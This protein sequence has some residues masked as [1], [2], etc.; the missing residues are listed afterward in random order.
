MSRPAPRVLT[1]VL[2]VLACW[3]PSAFA[4]TEITSCGQVVTGK[5]FLSAD[6]DCTGYDDEVLVHELFHDDEDA[7]V[8]GAAVIVKR[9]G[10]IELRGHTLTGGQLGIFC[11]KSCTVLGGGVTVT[12]SVVHGI[13]AS[14]NLTIK[15]TTVSNNGEAGLFV[16][17][18]LRATGCTI[19]GNRSGTWISATIKL[20]SSTVTGNA[21]FG[22]GADGV[23]LLDSSLSNNGVVDLSSKRRP[24]LKRSTC[25]TSSWGPNHL[26]V[27]G[28]GS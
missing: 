10:T 9:T 2:F 1:S 26:D 18:T 27:C 4:Q 21:E 28:G 25:E 13:I 5:A 16:N 15:D 8:V 6:L 17:R 24:H 11:G 14:K 22:I 20:V 19:S 7:S 23:S 12:G 3:I